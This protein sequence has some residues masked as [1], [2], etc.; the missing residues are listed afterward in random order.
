MGS[1][2][3]HHQ[4]GLW[5]RIWATT[6]GGC[7]FVYGPPIEGAVGHDMGA[8]HRFFAFV[9]LYNV[10]YTLYVMY[11]VTYTLYVMFLFWSSAQSQGYQLAFLLN[12]SMFKSSI[13]TDVYV[14][15]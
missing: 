5:V 4:R 11:N 9:Y 7:G 12:S 10:T 14:V 2:M 1:Y 6:R 15:A 13:F 3:G 8:P